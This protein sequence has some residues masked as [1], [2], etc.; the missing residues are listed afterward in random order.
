MRKKGF[1]EGP[2][3]LLIGV[4][5][6][7]MAIV[8]G[9]YLFNMINCWR[10]EEMMKI[11]TTELME[12]ISS[13][14]KGDVNSKKN[15]VVELSGY[16]AEGIYINQIKAPHTCRSFCPN[17]PNDCWVIMARSRCSGGDVLSKCIDISGNTVLS[18]TAGLSQIQ[19]SDDW[20]DDA[21]A[22]TSSATNLKIEKTGPDT[23]EIGKP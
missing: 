20:L 18:V 15:D 7:G 4:V 13:V 21:Y 1:A 14:G 2:F 11:Q 19:S 6:F 10:C 17:H 9:A 5:V 3:Q 12:A 23:I 16:C 22:I 8:V